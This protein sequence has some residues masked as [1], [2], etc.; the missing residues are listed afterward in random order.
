[1]RIKVFIR[2]CSRLAAVLIIVAL[3]LAVTSVVRFIIREHVK[4]TAV[5]IR[6]TSGFTR[7]ILSILGV[8]V[9]AD[10]KRFKSAEKI[11]RK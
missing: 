2:T 11:A 1:M 7:L 3:F 10:T 9:K 8:N 6:L 5:C 4:K